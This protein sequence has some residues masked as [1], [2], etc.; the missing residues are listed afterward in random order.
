MS[1]HIT[2]KHRIAV[3]QSTTASS[4]PTLKH[5]IIDDCRLVA[6]VTSMDSR[7]FVLREPSRQQIQVYDTKKFKQQRALR[8]KDLSDDTRGSGLA[9]CVTNNCIYVS[10]IRKNTVYKVKLSGKNKVYSWCVVDPHGLSINSS[11]NLLVA[12]CRANKILEYTTSGS[13]VREICLKSNDVVLYPHHAI[14]LTSDQFVISCL[15]VT[16]DETDDDDDVSDVVEVDTQ[17]RVVVSYRNQLKSTTQHEFSLSLRL[18]V[19]KNSEYTF[20]S[21]GN[22]HRIL[23]MNRLLSCCAR[24]LNVMSVDGGLQGPSCIYFDTSHNRLFVGECR[25]QRRVLVFD[26]VI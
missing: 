21:D 14:Q 17:G 15:N 13:F 18:S 25:G 20:V 1:C 23:I 2:I 19:D 9:L 8:V 10:D 11:C 6:D 7:L 24:E 4:T 16:N 26:N 12:S 22:N 3:I 5:V